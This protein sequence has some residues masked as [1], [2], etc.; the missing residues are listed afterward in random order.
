MQSSNET[1]KFFVNKLS[2]VQ[3]KVMGNIGMELDNLAT[4][5]TDSRIRDV[6][7]VNGDEKPEKLLDW[8]DLN[9]NAEPFDVILC[10]PEYKLERWEPMI[11]LMVNQL[12]RSLERR[13][14]R[15]YNAWELPPVL[16]MLDEFPRLG[17]VPAIRSG[18]MTLRGRGITI[19]LFVQ[20]IASLEEIYSKSASRV[21]IENCSYKAVLGATDV[22]SQNYFSTL[23]G[24]RKTVISGYSA[25]YDPSAGHITNYNGQVS[26]VREPIIFPEEFQTMQDIALFTPAGNFR[27]AKTL[28]ANHKEMF[29]RPEPDYS[30]IPIDEFP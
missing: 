19:A 5:V 13:P 11:R 12:I 8:A 3:E 26:E 17:K 29:L 24:T 4:L 25:S 1:A 7:T 27:I 18:L 28:F 16:L 30:K 21:I 23:Y 2:E 14:L 22:A 20:S 6:F 9:K 15:T 10:I